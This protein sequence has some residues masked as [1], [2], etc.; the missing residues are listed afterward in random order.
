MTITRTEITSDEQLHGTLRPPN[1]GGSE[2]G[3]LFGCH[4][5]LTAYALSA[6]KLGLLEPQIDNAVLRR[7]RLLEP[8]AVQ[9]L[10]EKKPNWT[11]W[12]PKI[13]LCDKEARLGATPDVFIER[14]DGIRG[15]VQIKTVEPSAFA[16]KWRN[17]AGEIEPPL[18]IALQA[19]LEAELAQADCA[20]V[21]ALVVGHSLDFELVEVPVTFR[22]IAAIRQRAAEFWK[23]I[24][25]GQPLDPDWGRDAE[26]VLA[27]H[28]ND[29]DSELDLTSDNELPELAAKLEAVNQAQAIGKKIADELKARI[30]HRIGTAQRVRF[31]GGSLTAKEVHRKAYTVAAT[32]YRRLSVKIERQVAEDAA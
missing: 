1:I 18:W 15:I 4:E 29:D 24:D 27:V 17:A 8:V 11:I 16:R 7:G 23:L 28:R 14:E 30:L 31:A 2:I 10:R 3:A 5:Y 22:V 20:Y 26:T 21:G 12:Q 32:S 13:Y 25:E 19:V 6:R 9:C